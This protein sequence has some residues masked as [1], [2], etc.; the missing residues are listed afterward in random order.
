[1]SKCGVLRPGDYKGFDVVRL[2]AF[3]PGRSRNEDAGDNDEWLAR[4]FEEESVLSLSDEE[5]EGTKPEPSAEDCSNLTEARAESPKP[6]SP[7]RK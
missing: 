3:V 1:M 5:E 7:C 4:A 2:F 6:Y